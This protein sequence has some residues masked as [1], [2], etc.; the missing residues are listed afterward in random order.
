MGI[1]QKT[2]LSG[3]TGGYL[4]SDTSERSRFEDAGPRCAGVT[5]ETHPGSSSDSRT[6]D[7]HRLMDVDGSR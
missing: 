3:V 1:N 6:V 5:P 2:V 7:T 4:P